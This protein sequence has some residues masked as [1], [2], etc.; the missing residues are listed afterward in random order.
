MLSTIL[1]SNCLGFLLL[2]TLTSCQAQTLS[3]CRPTP[4]ISPNVKPGVGG[5]SLSRD[6]K[7][8]VV[9]GGDAKIRFVDMS[10][11][12]VQRTLTGHTNAIYTAVFSPDEKLLASSS[13]DRTARIWDLSAGRELQKLNGFRCSVKAVAFSPNSQLL[14]ASGN[15]GMLKLWDAKSGKE[16]RSLVHI[17]SAVID[18]SVYS[19][20]FGRDG[21]KIYA[22]NGDGT[23]SEWDAVSGKETRTW[24]A[25]DQTTLKLLFSPDYSLLA[26]FGD[27]VVKLWDTSTWREVRSISMVRAP[28]TFNI[29]SALAFSHDG[30]L[31]A[32]SNIGLDQKQTSYVYVQTLV[33]N[34][35]TGEKLF[36]IEGHKFDIDGLMFTRDDHFLMTG[37][38]DTTIKFWD[39][40][41]GQEARTF[42]MPTNEKTN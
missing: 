1:H 3:N 10:T 12:A 42:T 4:P 40:K 11:G 27:A 2:L 15:D 35:M 25:H 33:W 31:I 9:A 22:A 18:M 38:V 36:T 28:A 39:M 17:N 21:N 24:K 32:A 26:S 5:L 16:L 8:L 29:S 37:S 14:A 7:T 23:I 13:R 6:G 41:T 34:V 19:L 30:K 20:A